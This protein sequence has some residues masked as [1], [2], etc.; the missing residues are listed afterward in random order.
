MNEIKTF[1]APT[2][3]AGPAGYVWSGTKRRMTSGFVPVRDRFHAAD[4]V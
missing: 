4:R 3:N 1:L 2:A